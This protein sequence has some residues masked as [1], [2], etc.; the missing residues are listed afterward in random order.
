MRVLSDVYQL[1]QGQIEEHRKKQIVFY[2]WLLLFVVLMLL[3]LLGRGQYTLSAT[4]PTACVAGLFALVRGVGIYLNSPTRTTK[5]IAEEME[6]LFGEDWEASVDTNTYAFALS[7]VR[8]R[9]QDRSGFLGHLLI[10]IPVG[11]YLMLASPVV[12]L[13]WLVILVSHAQ[14]AFPSRDRLARREREAWEM[15]QLHVNQLIPDKQKRKEKPKGDVR[16]RLGADG[17]LVEEE[18]SEAIDWWDEE[19]KSDAS[20]G[21]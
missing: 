12:V 18:E 17:E 21:S 6:L 7:R 15:L 20:T 14:N 10:F 4:L 5:R 3:S 19:P 13:V 2:V 11:L 16:Y 1:A 8:I 9:Q